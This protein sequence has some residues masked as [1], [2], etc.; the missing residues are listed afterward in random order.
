[1]DEVG[2]DRRDEL[3]RHRRRLRLIGGLTGHAGER[4]GRDE[5]GRDAVRASGGRETASESDDR[6]LRRGVGEVV[7]QPEDPGR[8]RHDDAAVALFDEVGP[9]CARRVERSAD[10]HGE[11]PRE[12]VGVGLGEPRPPDDAGVVDQDVE[13]SEALDRRVH[14]R[15]GA[16]L[17]GDVAAVGDRDPA[18]GDDLVDDIGGRCG[19]GPDTLHRAAEVV[20]DD[21]GPSVGEEA[22]VGPADPA[23]RSRDDGDAPVEPVRL[24]PRP[25]GV[26]RP[27]TILFG[28]VPR[29][30]SIACP[31]SCTRPPTASASSRSTVPR[32]ATRSTATWPSASRPRWTASRPIPTSGPGSSARTPRSSPVRSS[33]PVPTSTSSGRRAP[34]RPSTPS[35]AAS[36]GSCSAPGRNRSWSPSTVSRP[37]AVSRSSSPPTSSW[38][39]RGRRSASRRSGTT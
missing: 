34:R 23:P 1:M 12:V 11:M 25:L 26:Y 20:D 3:R 35:G 37:Q 38:R 19:V 14:E 15:L 13:A 27:V 4:R 6:R 24:H 9:R 21:A 18:G 36:P 39:R 33:A 31:P 7:G 5:V 10:V 28:L 32:P 17:G 22:R 16:G 8:G 2:D 30:G 29:R